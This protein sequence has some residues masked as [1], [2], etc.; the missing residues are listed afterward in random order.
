MLIFAIFLYKTF[1]YRNYTIF[2]TSKLELATIHLESDDDEEDEY[3]IDVVCEES[4]LEDDKTINVG[5]HG[6]NRV[7]RR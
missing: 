3:T 5:R 1:R 4:I 2:G 6:S 7:D